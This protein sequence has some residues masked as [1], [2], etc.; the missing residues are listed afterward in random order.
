ME[1]D[2]AAGGLTIGPRRVEQHRAAEA[3]MRSA[4]FLGHRK[5][6]DC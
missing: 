3:K 2:G 5:Q 1:I 6:G 4:G